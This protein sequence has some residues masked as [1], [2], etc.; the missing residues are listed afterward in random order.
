MNTEMLL[1]R[2]ENLEAALRTSNDLLRNMVDNPSV[3]S[4]YRLLGDAEDQV[5]ENESVLEGEFE[6]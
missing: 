6:E 2:I 5:S 3:G 1:A 4:L